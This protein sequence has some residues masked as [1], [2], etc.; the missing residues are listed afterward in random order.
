MLIVSSI[1]QVAV[2]GQSGGL[3]GPV[4]MSLIS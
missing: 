4:E 2:T 1:A 3:S